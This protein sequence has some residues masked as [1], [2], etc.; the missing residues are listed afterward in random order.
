MNNDISFGVNQLSRDVSGKTVRE[1]RALY[2]EALDIA[3][4]ATAR[5]RGVDATEE[6]VIGA[7]DSVVFTKKAGE[8]GC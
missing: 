6:T 5:V 1:V 2:N 4:G 7:G 3:P 8:K